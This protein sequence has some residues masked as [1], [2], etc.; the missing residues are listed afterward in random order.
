MEA[1]VGRVGVL[2]GAVRTHGEPAHRGRRPVVRQI[3]D[4]RQPWAAV[5]AGGE[6][7]AVAAV[8]RVGHLGQTV[9][10]GRDIRWDERTDPRQVPAGHDPEPLLAGHR[11]EVASGEIDHPRQRR[12]GVEQ[13]GEEVVEGAGR[14]LG[15][16]EHLQVVVAA[17]PGDPVP[18]RHD[19]DVRPEA[20][21]LYHPPQQVL[22]TDCGH[23]T[24][25]DGAAPPYC[26]DR[27]RVQRTRPRHARPLAGRPARAAGGG[28]R[29]VLQA[30]RRV[31]ERLRGDSRLERR[32]P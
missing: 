7:V 13:V 4:D 1:A 14:A 29:R 30:G 15:L 18:G 12:Q 20:D 26:P 19:G 27:G 32:D 16:D 8:G 21:T 3:L 28:T 10:A 23:H 17:P 5:G 24:L 11:R 2:R 22:P 31:A 25:L 6:R 9:R